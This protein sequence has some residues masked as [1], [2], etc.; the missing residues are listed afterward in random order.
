MMQQDII[1]KKIKPNT[2]LKNENIKILDLCGEGSYGSVYFC[3][4]NDKKNYVIKFSENETPE[5]LMK[6]YLLLKKICVKHIMCGYVLENENYNFYSIMNYGGITLKDYIKNNEEIPYN[7]IIS[8]LND[9][10]NFICRNKILLPD[11]KTSNIVINENHELKLID[12]YL[13]CEDCVKNKNCSIVRTYPTID[14]CVCHLHNEENYEYTYI[15]VLYG[16]ILLELFDCSIS[17]IH[18]NFCKKYNIT[19]KLKK[20]VLLFQLSCALYHNVS[21]NNKNYNDFLKES[22]KK[23][24]KIAN[25]YSDFINDLNDDLKIENLSNLFIP[26]PSLRKNILNINI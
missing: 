4:Y 19:I 26:I 10:I 8:Q 15:H 1:I 11:F 12:I 24:D 2:K 23:F 21:F 18:K 16:F 9:I 5:I 17:L 25:I 20:F 14:I 13:E 22:I 3:K 6:R 7:I